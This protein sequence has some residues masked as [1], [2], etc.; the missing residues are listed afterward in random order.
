VT[1]G[2]GVA[3]AVGFGVADGVAVADGEDG[4]AVV[5]GVRDGVG[6]VVGVPGDVAAEPGLVA[7]GSA[8]VG[9]GDVAPGA[10]LPPWSGEAWPQAV[11]ASASPVAAATEAAL[12]R[13]VPDISAPRCSVLLTPSD[14]AGGVE[15][16]PDADP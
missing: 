16:V 1:G 2:V 6:R 13:I 11:R 9:T 14:A 10:P 8:V 4:G 12:R 5:D 15:V 7:T 3:G